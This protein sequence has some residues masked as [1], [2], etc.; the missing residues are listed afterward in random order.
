MS[1]FS[2]IVFAGEA[3]HSEERL[4]HTTMGRA[5]LVGGREMKTSVTSCASL[6]R[7]PFSL[8]VAKCPS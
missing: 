3:R 4:A 2:P 1:K 8:F 6:F 5:F 7:C